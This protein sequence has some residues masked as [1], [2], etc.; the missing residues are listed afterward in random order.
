MNARAARTVSVVLVV[1]AVVSLLTA[2]GSV[3][4]VSMD[5][6]I[7][8]QVADDGEA[9]VSVEPVTDT[10]A[11]ADG[12]AFWN[13][14]STDV[15]ASSTDLITVSNQ[16]GDTITVT[17]LEAPAGVELDGTGTTVGPGESVNIS[18]TVDCDRLE[19]EPTATVELS[20]A[21]IDVVQSVDLEATCQSG[22]D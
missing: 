20:G 8:V 18:G 19:E 13:D 21:G 12:D 4:V 6:T 10:T 11:G 15:A 7:S 3:S 22:S 5:R 1:A 14:D 9:A 17:E 2:T 16:F